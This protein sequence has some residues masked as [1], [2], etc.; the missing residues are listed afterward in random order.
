MIS[1]YEFSTAP[2]FYG[3]AAAAY[4]CDALGFNETAAHH[5]EQTAKAIGFIK[6]GCLNCMFAVRNERRKVWTDYADACRAE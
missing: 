1:A 3:H 5:A 4:V 6:G 2:N